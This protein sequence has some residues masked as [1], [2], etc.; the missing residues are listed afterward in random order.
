MFKKKPVITA[1]VCDTLEDLRLALEVQTGHR[2]RFRRIDL[3]TGRGL[4]K[5]G[6]EEKEF[7]ICE[8]NDDRIHFSL[9]D[10][11]HIGLLNEAR[12]EIKVSRNRV[13]NER[14]TIAGT[15][16]MR[17]IGTSAQDRREEPL[18][19]DQAKYCASVRGLT[20][21]QLLNSEPESASQ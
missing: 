3:N 13:P 8:S 1:N 11:W 12:T 18:F 9:N 10:G 21:D 15:F 19:L 7:W 5:L 17:W 4:V 20:L 2:P 6:E 14:Q 16:T